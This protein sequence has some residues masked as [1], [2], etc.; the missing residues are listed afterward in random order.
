MRICKIS[1]AKTLYI[2]DSQAELLTEY[3]ADQYLIGTPAVGNIDN[4]NELEIV[5]GGYSNQGK[6]FA[7]NIA[8]CLNC[9][10]PILL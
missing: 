8:N 4:D 5:F 3:Y 9:S 10:I 6:I 1:S 2:L 7:I